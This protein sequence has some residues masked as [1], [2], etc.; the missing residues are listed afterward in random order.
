MNKDELK[1]L[2]SKQIEG[3]VFHSTN[4]IRQK[5]FES[6]NDDLNNQE[7]FMFKNLLMKQVKENFEKLREKCKNY[8]L[9]ISRFCRGL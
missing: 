1:D 3:L 6:E 2:A 7:N 5:S 9:I 8:F 4:L